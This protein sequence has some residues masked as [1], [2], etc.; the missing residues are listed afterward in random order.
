MIPKNTDT[1]LKA[2]CPS[3]PCSADPFLEEISDKIRRGEPVGMWEALS[4]IEYQRQRK[5]QEPPTL[6]KRVIRFFLPNDKDLARR[7]LDS[8]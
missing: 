3:A 7:A 2:D 1:P 5:L 8:E 6:W 4:A